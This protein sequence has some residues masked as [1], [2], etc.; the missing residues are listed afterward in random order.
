MIS[1][2]ELLKKIT[3][4]AEKDGRYRKEAYMFIL[5]SLEFTLSKLKERRHLTGQEF[6]KGIA[7]YAREQYGYLAKV[8]FAHWG[9]NSTLDYGEIVYL[10]IDI[11]LMN[12]TE[13]DKKE[14]FKD[15][16]V[17][18]KEFDWPNSLPAD[19]FDEL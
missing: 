17:F 9:I 13:D 8:V 19:F 7:E 12:K 16:Y 14:D 15:V 2:I 10:L 3:D 5:A 4:L 6:S 1:N 11:G 18:D